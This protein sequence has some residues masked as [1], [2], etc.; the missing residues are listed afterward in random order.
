MI[1]VSIVSHR[2]GAM[3]TRLASDL[4]KHCAGKAE[5][6]LTENVPEEGAVDWGHAGVPVRV[7]RNEVPRGFGANHNAAFRH[8]RGDL[9]CVLNPDVRLLSDPFP[10][11]ARELSSPGV[12][13]AA[14]LIVGSDGAIQDS[15]RR[16]PTPVSLLRKSFSPR[17]GP[18]YATA[19]P[20]SPDWVAGM[21]MLFRREVYQ[22]I[23]GFDERYLLYYEDVDL[24]ARLRLK[25]YD[26]RVNP[27]ARAVHDGQRESH[28]NPAYLARHLS[29]VLRYFLSRPYSDLRRQRRL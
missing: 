26:I 17:R 13:L 8:A 19:A 24:C 18:D 10:V 22:D 4:V 2:H 16:F 9:F 1:S 12:G 21:F 25:G 14:P 7:L 11:L 23:G 3:A 20:F 15:A 29:S 27:Q 5:I 28:G 6:L